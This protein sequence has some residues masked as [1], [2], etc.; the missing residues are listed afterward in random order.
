[1]SDILFFIEYYINDGEMDSIITGDAIYADE[2]GHLGYKDLYQTINPLST[3][4]D[5]IALKMA[6]YNIYALSMQVGD[7]YD[8]VYAT[9]TA[10]LNEDA[11]LYAYNK[12]YDLRYSVVSSMPEDATAGDY[13]LY[14]G[15]GNIYTIGAVYYYTGTEYIKIN[16]PKE[17]TGYVYRD[18]LTKHLNSL[19]NNK[20]NYNY[21]ESLYYELEKQFIND[22]IGVLNLAVNK[23][24]EVMLYSS[25]YDEIKLLSL[26]PEEFA[27]RIYYYLTGETGTAEDL[28]GA[29]LDGAEGLLADMLTWSTEDIYSAY[30]NKLTDWWTNTIPVYGDSQLSV[31]EQDFISEISNQVGYRNNRNVNLVKTQTIIYIYQ[32]LVDLE[33]YKESTMP[34]D[35]RNPDNEREYK[36]FVVNSLINSEVM[37]NSAHSVTLAKAF[38]DSYALSSIKELATRFDAASGAISIN[39]NET[40]SYSDYIDFINKALTEGICSDDG[41][42]T[43]YSEYLDKAIEYVEYTSVASDDTYINSV[44]TNKLF[45]YI[46]RVYLNKIGHNIGANAIDGYSLNENENV[47][48]QLTLNWYLNKAKETCGV[49]FTATSSFA[50]GN[51]PGYYLFTGATGEYINGTVYKLEGGNYIV[52]FSLYQTAIDLLINRQRIVSQVF[53]S[54][55]YVDNDEDGRHIIYFDRT[56]WEEFV[57]NEDEEKGTA[58]GNIANSDIY[59]TN[60]NKTTKVET[61]EGYSYTNSFSAN[62]ITFKITNANVVRL[63]FNYVSNSNKGLYNTIHIDALAPELPTSVYAIGYTG[64][65]VSEENSYVLGYVKITGYSES[66]Y[67]LIFDNVIKTE[68]SAYYVNILGEDNNIIKV[69]IDVIYQD[70]SI[71]YMY[72][73]TGDYSENP[74]KII[75]NTSP[76]VDMYRL[77]SDDQATNVIY[78]DP[79]N[80][81]T[82]NANKNGYILPTTLGVQYGDG[83]QT[84]ISNVEWVESDITFN[85]K[86]TSGE[87]KVLNIATYT[88]TDTK[89]NTRKIEFNYSTKVVTIS[90]LNELGLAISS[91]EYTFESAPQ[92]NLKV[93]IEDRTVQQI[94]FY[95]GT[96]YETLGSINGFGRID[97]TQSGYNINQFYPEYPTQLRVYFKD[98]DSN[99]SNIITLSNSDWALGS[100]QTALRTI[101]QNRQTEG[102]FDAVFKYLGYNISVEFKTKSIQLPTVTNGELSTYIQGGTLYAIIGGESIYN[103]I[104]KHYSVMYFNFGTEEEPNWQKVPVAFDSS[105]FSTTTAQNPA[106]LQV[107]GF[108]GYTSTNSID[109]GYNIVFTVKVIDPNAY[110]VLNNSENPFVTFDYYIAARDSAGNKRTTADEPNTNGDTYLL[111][112]K[113]NGV[114]EVTETFNVLQG[115]IKYDFVNNLVTI[116]MT[117]ILE[118]AD[119][120]L[121]AD[122]Y[123]TRE[124]LISLTMPLRSYVYTNITNPQFVTTK[125]GAKWTWT[126]EST[127]SVN[128]VD[129]IYWPLGEEM[130]ASDLPTVRDAE[131]GVEISLMWDLT[132]LNVNLANATE[133]EKVGTTIYGYYMSANGA[134]R[135]IPLVVYIEQE[136]VTRR[137]IASVTG[138]GDIYTINKTYDAHYYQLPFDAST[139]TYLRSDGTYAALDE[140]KY[141][142]EYM[143]ISVDDPVW[144]STAYPMDAGTYY[145]RIVFTDYNVYVSYPEDDSYLFR[146]VIN[147]MVVKVNEIGFV[148]ENESRI[149]YTYS[150]TSTYLIVEQGLPSVTADNWFTAGEKAHLVS[151]YVTLGYTQTNA[152]ALAYMEI[153]NRV[154]P[155]VQEILAGYYDELL[156]SGMTNDA[157]IKESIYT[158]RMPETEFVYQE[159]D[160]VATYKQSG[161]DVPYPSDVGIY[162]VTIDIDTVNGNYRTT[163]AK[164]ITLIISK[165]ESLSYTVSST[166]PYNGEAQN[167]IIEQL[168]PVPKGVKITYTYEMTDDGA[169]LIIINNGGTLSISPDSTYETSLLGIKDF[170]QGGYQYTIT[171]EGG[172]NFIDGVL[173]GTV[174]ITKSNVYVDLENIVGYYLDDIVNINDYIRIYTDANPTTSSTKLYGLDTIN[175]L[176][177]LITYSDVQS[178]Y[179]VGEYYMSILGLALTANAT[180]TYTKALDPSIGRRFNSKWFSLLQLKPAN[181]DGS[182]LKYKE[183]DGSYTYNALY[184]LFNN[185]NIYVKYDS[186]LGTSGGAAATYTITTVDGAIGVS[187]NQE[188]QEIISNLSNGDDIVLYLEP[189]VNNEA[190]SAIEIN[191]DASVKLV[192]YYD[193]S[194][195]EINTV[196]QG[197]KLLRG[198]LIMQIISVQNTNTDTVGLLIGDNANTVKIYNCEFVGKESYTSTVGISTTKNYASSIYLFETEFEYLSTG[199]YM[200]NGGLEMERCTLYNN[201]NGIDFIPSSESLNIYNS[202]FIENTNGVRTMNK[203]SILRYNTFARNELAI[204]IS[205][206]TNIE[207]QVVNEFESNIINIKE[208]E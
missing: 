146:F 24:I 25:I 78:I 117:Y 159:T 46:S 132:N 57:E 61:N 189:L 109:G 165:D 63:Y 99:I 66:F 27:E 12:L 74:N 187:T 150:S 9:E 139:I 76:F 152:R 19:L 29:N 35:Y 1:M 7:A 43:T 98:G 4:L 131:T 11:Y 191:V 37:T 205:E 93:Y 156:S 65:V 111:L 81:N 127:S 149:E 130:T 197:I 118:N 182:I 77:Y 31:A 129:A 151:K 69:V 83:T 110:A 200:L 101:I 185:Y 3:E 33:E 62:N 58:Q 60:A 140:S 100:S 144:S 86:G 203:D 112:T 79:L 207:I 154:A 41:F 84:I 181:E 123:G 67:E 14:A 44:G 155:R 128:Y 175:D 167:P 75:D 105:S 106:T 45:A 168:N 52:Q 39:A 48:G 164:T 173:G 17:R 89:R 85:I 166:L 148:G 47:F 183:A 64:S 141:T 42:S 145:I 104:V 82:L 162:S 122:A 91:E 204:L 136:E 202:T 32:F 133:N 194:T 125:T 113:V 169:Q 134:W 170:R 178:Y 49:T 108:L 137:I 135:S 126:T 103:Q 196:I 22:E 26:T 5:N 188:L 199:V 10:E 73:D 186:E 87:Y 8:S 116:P 59:I 143:N 68:D 13:Y 80:V 179:P 94:Y 192:G 157:A 54:E 158:Y 30:L 193:T 102:K 2:V 120:R 28:L 114:Y 171:I 90:I 190:Y 176:G 72:V 20:Y 23:A 119:S 92:W 38:I 201:Y 97:A 115:D 96:S 174:T 56:E 195:K 142:I 21:Y 50:S 208:G 184:T 160:I 124:R 88:Y 18:E 36:W 16:T 70:R 180:T 172:N 40:Y 107:T 163:G 153:Y 55:D 121:A 138:N 34:A 6:R 71:D 198:A 51:T 95:N 15:T 177:A 147:P 206:L 161:Q 53:Y